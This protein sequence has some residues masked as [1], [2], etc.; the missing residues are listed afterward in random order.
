MYCRLYTVRVASFYLFLFVV[1][2]KGIATHRDKNERNLA[3]VNTELFRSS[4]DVPYENENENTPV[5][6]SDRKSVM[7]LF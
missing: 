3:R 1:E 2:S 5:V 6:R 4:L 7:L